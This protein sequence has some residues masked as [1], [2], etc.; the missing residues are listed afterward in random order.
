MIAAIDPYCQGDLDSLCGVYAI[1]NALSA[2]CPE[3]DEDIAGVLFGHLTR[4]MEGVVKRPMPALAY[5]ISGEG[6]RGLLARAIRFV[7]K[8]LEIEIETAECQV[9][10]RGLELRRL[11]RGGLYVLGWGEGAVLRRRGPASPL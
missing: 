9:S 4:H 6:V 5:G 8:N 7:R 2:L 11:W 1:I 3:L 10:S